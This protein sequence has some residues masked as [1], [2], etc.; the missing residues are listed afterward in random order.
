MSAS[1]LCVETVFARFLHA[2][3]VFRHTHFL[4]SEGVPVS[5]A[6][7]GASMLLSTFFLGAVGG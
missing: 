1:H 7:K 6:D 2:E 5:A 3:E 4:E